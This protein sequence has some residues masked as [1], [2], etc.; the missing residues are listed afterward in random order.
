MTNATPPAR[1]AGRRMRRRALAVLSI[2]LALAA[3]FGLLHGLHVV[4]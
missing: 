4:R 1:P 3:G 2:Y